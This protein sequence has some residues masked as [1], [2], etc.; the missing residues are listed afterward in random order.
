MQFFSMDLLSN[1]GCEQ[2]EMWHKGSLGGEDAQTLNTR[3]AQRKCV[4]PHSTMK[5]NCN[6]WRPL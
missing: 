5:T 6:I 4:I 3:M 1:G 2:N